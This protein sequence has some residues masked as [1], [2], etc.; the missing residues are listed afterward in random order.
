MTREEREAVKEELKARISCAELLEKSKGSFYKCPY[1]GSG[2]G[3]HSSGAVHIGKNK[4]GNNSFTCHSCGANGDIIDLY[5]QRHGCGYAEAVE[6]LARQYGFAT[7]SGAQKRAQERT[8]TPQ[9]AQNSESRTN[10]RTGA[11]SAK[12][13]K[14][15]RE[16]E[17]RDFSA[18]FAACRERIT[19]PEAAEYLAARGISTA[20]AAAAGVGF[21]PA[22][23]PAESGNPCARLIIP[24]GREA[25]TT[26]ATDP[27]AAYPKLQAKGCRAGIFH[28]E[29]LTAAAPGGVVFVT[30]G[31]FDALAVMEA[32]GSA[33]ALNSATNAP[34]LFRE[35]LERGT[36]A[37]L[38]LCLDADEAGADA[39][40]HIAAKLER[41]EV[42]HRFGNICGACKDPAAHLAENRAEFV[43][44]VQAETQKGAQERTGTPQSEESSESRTNTRAEDKTRENGEK[45][46]KAAAAE[47]VKCITCYTNGEEKAAA[48]D[49]FGDPAEDPA[50]VPGAPIRSDSQ[51][52]EILAAALREDARAVRSGADPGAAAAGDPTQEHTETREEGGE[53]MKRTEASGNFKAGEAAAA[54]PADVMAYFGNNA[55]FD[56][57]GKQRAPIKTGFACIDRPAG[58]LCSGLYA[59]AA[60]PAIGKTSLCLQIAD[61]LA[62]A[63][64]DVVFFSLEQSRIELVSKSIARKANSSKN[65]ERNAG[66]EITAQAV[67]LAAH[68][69]NPNK[70]ITWAMLAYRDTVKDRLNIVEGNFSL[71]VDY[72]RGYLAGYIKRTGRRPVVFVDYLQI[73]RPG[74]GGSG[75][76]AID[77][78][79]TALKRTSRE[80]DTPIIAISSIN[81]AGYLSGVEFESLKESGA[82]EFSCDAVWG[83]ELYTQTTGKESEEQRREA[84]RQAMQSNPRLLRFTW[85]KNR[86]GVAGCGGLL[87][88]NPARE[89]FTELAEEKKT[90]N[91]EKLEHGA[92]RL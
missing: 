61:T 89:M 50:A 41:L 29:A 88:Y 80:Y 23:D 79:I 17:K 62:A 85:L 91:K 40:R 36:R 83:L 33:L 5:E 77:D 35:I 78:I 74:N 39:Q 21:D 64:T 37:T 7:G 66:E 14:N 10:T 42:P 63:G 6:E 34:A 4:D 19:E 30:E 55:F 53:E 49:G 13:G 60:A 12:N 44:A 46:N 75:K 68:R 84:R 3:R 76:E 73:I 90:T 38:V 26:R 87:E 43:A 65:T 27:G 8:G 82:I 25:Y 71:D 16:G 45:R 15:E 52:G 9:R 48:A 56:E 11:K 1:C 2:T 47:N 51:G 81:R 57:L 28:A 24:T 92:K 20:T 58:G 72:I 18:Y 86:A 31:A 22:A 59:L 69:E 54:A 70:A 32:G 67:R